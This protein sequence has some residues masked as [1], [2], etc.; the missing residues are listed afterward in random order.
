MYHITDKNYTDIKIELGKKENDINI[1]HNIKMTNVFKNKK[2]EDNH[3]DNKIEKD[4]N[5]CITRELNKTRVKNNVECPDVIY[6]GLLH[7]EKE[8]GDD[9]EDGEDNVVISGLNHLEYIEKN[10][11]VLFQ[12]PS[13]IAGCIW[14][15]HYA[16][17][18]K[19]SKHN[20]IQYFVK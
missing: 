4:K 10:N 17:L 8:N 7:E 3:N 13:A 6:E 15:D 18:T 14:K 2:K 11:I 9:E 16:F 19:K 1:V 12:H 5:F 20:N